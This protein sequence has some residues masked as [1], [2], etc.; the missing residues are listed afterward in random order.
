LKTHRRG[1]TALLAASAAL[2]AAVI[3]PA[4][5]GAAVGVTVTGDDGNPVPI[6]GALNIRNM[7]PKLAISSTAA[8]RFSL[9]V[10]GPNGAKVA[11]DLNCFSNYNTS[12]KFVDY[13]GNGVYT[14]TVTTYT[15]VGCTAGASQ[16][17]LPFTITASTSLGQPQGP[18]LT[19]K[20]GSTIPNT[21]SLPIDLNPGAL[22]TEAFVARNVT[23]NPDGSLP[24][25][26][27]QIFPDTTTRTVPVRLDD[28]PG[29][30]VVAAHAKGY[31]GGLNPQAFGPWAAPAAIRAFAPFDLQKFT[32]S[33]Q[34]GPSYRF[35]ATIRATGASGRVNVAIG[36]G[37]KGKYRSYG[38]ARISKQRFSKRFRLSRTG[39]Y[40]IRFKY[41]G[42]AT[43]A[44]GFEVRSFQ[45]RRTIRFTSAS[46]AG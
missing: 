24:G 19:R 39:S 35:S 32:W 43:V 37:K 34:R 12:G 17:N 14:V 42:N 6:A 38:T 8:D 18:V 25:T 3:A 10:T 26:P 2:G 9:S 30:Y 40:R 46:I 44:G 29:V 45:I 16:Q 31:T 33:D 28:G 11:S 4:A 1:R 20:A 36:R 22:S 23:P 41:K 7:N 15:N 21:I 13:V 5:A 27:E